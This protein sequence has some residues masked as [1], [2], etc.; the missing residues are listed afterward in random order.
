LM[1][2]EGVLGATLEC[3]S[4]AAGRPTTGRCEACV[5]GSRGRMS[6]ASP[7]MHDH[8]AFLATLMHLLAP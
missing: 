7:R 4:Y 3:R 2:R 5:R 1:H 8:R 6:H